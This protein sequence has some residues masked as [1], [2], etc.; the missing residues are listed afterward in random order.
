MTSRS[1]ARWFLTNASRPPINLLVLV[2]VPVV[3][4]VVAAGPMADAAELLGGPGGPAV[5]TA[6][7]GWAAGFIAAV[8]TYLQMRAARAANRRLLLAGLAPS[9]LVGARMAIGLALA[10]L[11][12]LTVRTSKTDE[13][14]LEILGFRMEADTSPS[15]PNSG[16]LIVLTMSNATLTPLSVITPDG[17]L[18]VRLP[19]TVSTID[20]ATGEETVIASTDPAK[21]ATLRSESIK[22]FPPVNQTWTLQEPVTLYVAGT[23]AA[24][25]SAV[26][27]LE[28]FNLTVNQPA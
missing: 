12:A 27:M 11:A 28:G 10:P 25:G 23:T 4:V 5:Q 20:K 24:E 1:I 18:L 6:T 26:G 2:L 17:M 21:Y 3:F 8:G 9:W 15:T 7:A 19:L 22:S 13:L 14:V 16:T